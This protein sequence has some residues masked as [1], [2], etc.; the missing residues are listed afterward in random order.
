MLKVVIFD[1]DGTLIASNRLHLLTFQKAFKEVFG[2][3][4]EKAELLPLFGES[5]RE[6]AER[7]LETHGQKASVK[8]LDGFAELKVK[9]YDGVIE[10][11][12]LMHKS[13]FAFLK[14]LKRK[15]LK[16]AIASGTERKMLFAS[17]KPVELELFDVLICANDVKRSK[18]FPD[19]LNL[20]LKK[21]KLGRKECLYVG[22]SLPDAKAARTAGMKFVGFLSGVVSRKRFES[23]KSLAV[24]RKIPELGRIVEKLR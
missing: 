23:V 5:I 24:I 14:K 1:L 21:L 4:L 12:H 10:K 13:T 7:M 19:E 22:D 20:A 6:I 9:L 2:I 15:G 11:K 18:P 3:S 8:K 17:L 16:L